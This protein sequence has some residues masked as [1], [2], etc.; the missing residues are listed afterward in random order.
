MNREI[1]FRAWDTIEK[2]WYKANELEI[3]SLMADGGDRYKFVEFTG[4][5]DKNKNKIYEGDTLEIIATGERYEVIFDDGCFYAHLDGNVL[6]QLSEVNN[7]VDIMGNK[8]EK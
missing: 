4:L 7:S 2:K 1:K 5:K 6:I 3:F 8:W